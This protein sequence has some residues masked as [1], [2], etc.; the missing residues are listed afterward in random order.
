MG[1]ENKLLSFV[2]SINECV[3][4]ASGTRIIK[5]MLVTSDRVS[6]PKESGQRKMAKHPSQTVLYELGLIFHC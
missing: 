3:S 5:W 4:Q 2:Q 1:P 6:A